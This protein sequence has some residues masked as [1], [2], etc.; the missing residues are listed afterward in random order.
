MNGSGEVL[1]HTAAQKETSATLSGHLQSLKERC[2]R[3]AVP[4]PQYFTCDDAKAWEKTIHKV[5]PDAEVLQD[6]KHL[7][8]R[9][10]EV[11]GVSVDG[12]AQFSIDLHTAFTGTN[13]IPVRSRTGK[14]HMV[15]AP[16]D[17][18]KTIIERCETLIAQ[19]RS[20][21]PTMFSASF[22]STWDTQKPQIEKYVKDPIV[23]GTE[24]S[25]I[26]KIFIIPYILLL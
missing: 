5:F 9:M 6:I 21:Y 23:E 12:S 3:L 8:N 10:I 26:I 2:D 16:L 15:E 7:I 1:S 18:G 25:C 22:D 13:K 4:Y 14:V 11:I 20:V 24:N 19:Y 17:H